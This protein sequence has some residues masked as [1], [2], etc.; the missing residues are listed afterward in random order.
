MANL[1]SSFHIFIIRSQASKTS[2]QC[3]LYYFTYTTNI[4][5]KAWPICND[6][7][8]SVICHK[9]LQ[10]NEKIVHSFAL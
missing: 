3:R 9:A 1:S 10:M 8:T 2:A 7:I 5:W 6:V 4:T